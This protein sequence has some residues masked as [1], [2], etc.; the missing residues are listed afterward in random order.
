MT[1]YFNILEDLLI[2]FRLPIFNKKAKRE[3]LV[4]EK[5]FYFD[6]GVYRKIRPK[7]PL[8]S[9]EEIDGAS[10]ETLLIQEMRALNDYFNFEYQF[11]F[12][13]TKKNQEIDLIL[14]GPKGLIAIEVKRSHRLKDENYA[15]LELFKKGYPM[16][17]CYYVYGGTKSHN[18]QDI[19]IIPFEDFFKNLKGVLKNS[20]VLA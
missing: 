9:S 18:H 6:N 7:G 2:A 10:L 1:D 11:Y 19:Q 17:I 4:S 3:L 12:W 8:D 15:A 16:A 5:F 14:Y 13:R 20:K